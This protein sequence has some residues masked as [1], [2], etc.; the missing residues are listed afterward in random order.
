MCLARSRFSD[1]GTLCLLCFNYF[2]P[3]EALPGETRFLEMQVSLLQSLSLGGVQGA[4][5]GSLILP[6][7]LLL[8]WMSLGAQDYQTPQTFGSLPSHHSSAVF[9]ERINQA[10]HG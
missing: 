6:A 2:F 4:K 3:S 5:L 9:K 10:R 7:S 8:P 1:E